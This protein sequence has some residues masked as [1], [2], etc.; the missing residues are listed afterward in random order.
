MEIFSI[1]QIIKA[2]YWQGNYS[3]T[4]TDASGRDDHSKMSR[5]HVNA[6]YLYFLLKILDLLDTV[7]LTGGCLFAG[8]FIIFDVVCSL[9]QIFFLLRKRFTNITFLHVYH[10]SAMVLAVYIATRYLP[11]GQATMLGILNCM[12]HCLMYGYYL[13]SALNENVAHSIWWKKHI[14]QIQMVQFLMLVIH[15]TMGL[16]ATECTYPKSISFVMAIQNLFMLFMFGDFYI[17][18]YFKNKSKVQ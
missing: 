6:T 3:L 16:L 5:N 13:V 2:T 10:H 15:F 12:V 18:A 14:T 4:C 11:A 17:K 8:D 1:V 7:S 9:L